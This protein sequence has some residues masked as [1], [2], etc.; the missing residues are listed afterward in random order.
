MSDPQSDQIDYAGKL[1]DVRASV[2]P[3]LQVSRHIFSGEPT[4][5]VRDPVTAVSHRF[6][7]EDYRL[8]VS[9][10]QSTTL[11]E[12]LQALIDQGKIDESQSNDYYRFVVHLHQVGLLTLPLSDGAALHKR[13]L[14]R[15]EA[16][17]K[18]KFTKLL[19]LK[20]P[21]VKPDQFLNHTQHLWSLFF[22]VPAF[23]LWLI[24]AVASLTVVVAHWKEFVD[25]LGSML[26]LENLP[27]LWCLLV[28][29]KVFHEL[30]H[31]YAC[32]V[33]GGAVPE[34]GAIFIMGTPC[35]YVDA[36][37]SWG[38]VNRWHR[39]VVALAGMYFESM[40][41]MVALVVWL[42]TEGGQVHSAA[43]YALIL[44]T[45]VTIGFNANPLMRY[46]GYFV[47]CDLVNIPNLHREA[48]STAVSCIKRVLFWIDPDGENGP[49]YSDNPFRGLAM[50][51]FGFACMIYQVSVSIGMGLLLGLGVPIVGPLI[52]GWMVL[53]P[54]FAK[55]KAIGHY[56][57]HSEEISEC[58]GR[59]QLVTAA[60][61]TLV[62]AVVTMVP[63]PGRLEV[64]GILHRSEERSVRAEVDGFVRT[65]SAKSGT[66][67]K[68]NDPLYEL[69]NDDLI[70]QRAAIKA[71]AEQ[72]TIQLQS[73]VR[74]DHQVAQQYRHQLSSE[75]EKLKDLDRRIFNLRVVSPI[76]GDF[77]DLNQSPKPGRYVKRG[78]PLGLICSGL[79]VV[80]AKL[81]A[82]Q[83]ARIVSEISGTVRVKLVGVS[84]ET[85]DGVVIQYQSS[86][87][88]QIEDAALTSSGGGSIAV[89]QE[90]MASE[91][92]F[93]IVVQVDSF[94]DERFANKVKVGM[95]A[96]LALPTSNQTAGEWLYRRSMRL[97]NQ[98]RLTST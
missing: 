69:E 2:R 35:A 54:L 33:F 84:G 41:A 56:L 3:N 23:I 32:K 87:S 57:V 1:G 39:M 16:Q 36:S 40:L 50:T 79:W 60:G 15:Q 30:G 88:R 53:T 83:W 82:D 75:L 90:M 34:M 26:A 89:S 27:V 17:A 8:L 97:V 42:L 59:A 66:R 63:I 18:G 91:N 5:V 48:K 45:I 25:P 55:I 14:Q 11:K 38:F 72:L 29:L 96:V 13:Y 4:Y 46:D 28:G 78:E 9:V 61:L 10:N 19:F 67:L 22:T 43:Q 95:S 77:T 93:D 65:I 52:A 85:F 47:L 21:L 7:A 80:K 70:A 62:L 51:L 12:S 71:A 58:R 86:G 98:L 68:P 49:R 73:S 31:A 6:S 24:C 20:V 92:F 81:T 44:S 74:L 94:S 37:A 76:A 64:S